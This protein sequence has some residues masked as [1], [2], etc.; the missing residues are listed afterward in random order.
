MNRVIIFGDS[1]SHNDYHLCT[2]EDYSWC[3]MFSEKI[4]AKEVVNMSLSGSNVEYSI[5]KLFQFYLNGHF[6]KNDIVIF[7]VSQLTRSP[8]NTYKLCGLQPAELS[9]YGLTY[10]SNFGMTSELQQHINHAGS[11]YD[12]F[13]STMATTENYVDSVYYSL[14][15]LFKAINLQTIILS[16]EGVSCQLI[17]KLKTIDAP[18]H[19]LNVPLIQITMG[20]IEF[21][22]HGDT[23]Y[24]LFGSE[25]R[26]NHLCKSNH[27]KLCDELLSLLN[28]D[29]M[30]KSVQPEIFK[31]KILSF[32]QKPSDNDLIS[33]G[34]ET[35]YYA[36]E[37]IKKYYYV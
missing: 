34:Y 18:V 23:V 5:L 30:V 37:K 22:N 21:R 8:L 29:S 13:Y 15:Y 33:Y 25:L 2:G 9:L 11:F 27:I 28:Y 6:Q 14:L 16:F 1:Y 19:I 4:K 3:A 26:N 12:L 35:G 7:V 20:E 10:G 36:I 31:N 24:S 17:E 32:K